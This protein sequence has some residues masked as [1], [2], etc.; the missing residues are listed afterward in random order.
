MDGKG[1]V[2]RSIFSS[3]GAP[4]LATGG[5]EKNMQTNRW[6]EAPNER[7][8]LFKITQPCAARESQ[9]IMGIP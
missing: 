8:R 1:W 6:Y 3:D 5:A 9:P 7:V 2:T 4:V